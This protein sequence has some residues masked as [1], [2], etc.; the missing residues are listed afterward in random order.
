M[1]EQNSCLHQ[2]FLFI[3]TALGFNNKIEKAS[4]INDET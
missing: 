4:E 3:I 1:V 2:N